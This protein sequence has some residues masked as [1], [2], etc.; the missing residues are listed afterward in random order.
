MSLILTAIPLRS[1]RADNSVPNLPYSRWRLVLLLT[2]VALWSACDVGDECAYGEVQCDGNTAR[3]C[4]A[5]ESYTSWQTE[6]CGTKTCVIAKEATG[7]TLAFCA[8]SPNLDPRCIEA[9]VPN[10]EGD[11]LVECTAGYATSARSCATSCIALDDHPDRC[12]GEIDF[13]P[14]RCDGS[15][16]YSC[17]MEGPGINTASGQVPG[18]C[19]EYTV[20]SEAGYVVYSQHCDRGSLLA[21]TRCAQDCGF[22]SDC[23]SACL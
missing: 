21:R 4:V 7:P 18:M 13:G 3:T 16:G 5:S 6:A 19:S 11:T 20:P 8:L 2:P 1:T 15:S 12:V 17:V 23:S 14:D 9:D 22:L 10:C